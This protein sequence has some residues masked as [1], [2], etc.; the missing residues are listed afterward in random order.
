[1]SSGGWTLNWAD[2]RHKGGLS[3]DSTLTAAVAHGFPLYPKLYLRQ[4]LGTSLYELPKMPT[5]PPEAQRPSNAAAPNSTDNCG[6]IRRTD[7]R[8]CL[9]Y[10][11]RILVLQTH[12]NLGSVGGGGQS[13]FCIRTV[14][15]VRLCRVLFI[16]HLLAAG[17]TPGEP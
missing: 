11:W 8:Q 17:D 5:L 12:D 16:T 2:S 13:C 9:P 7:K 6:G 3:A 1:M 4:S 15:L 14:L 10:W